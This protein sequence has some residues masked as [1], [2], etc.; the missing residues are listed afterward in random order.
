MFKITSYENKYFA[1]PTTLFNDN[2]GN[3]LVN[4]V[5]PKYSY[6]AQNS[7]AMCE[8][9]ID[10]NQIHLSRFTNYYLSYCVSNDIE[11]NTPFKGLGLDLLFNVILYLLK[12]NK[13]TED[14]IFSVSTDI[15]NKKLVEYYNSLSFIHENEYDK[16][17]Q[18]GLF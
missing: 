18:H 9:F 7:F 4:K 14:Y 2:Y 17:L 16:V 3:E 11:Y 10:N 15:K 12:E 5:C 1:S 6:G 13:I 8:L